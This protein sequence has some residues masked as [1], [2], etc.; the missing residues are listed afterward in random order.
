MPP[1]VR[2]AAAVVGEEGLDQDSGRAVQA[3][4]EFPEA[5]AP[6]LV[7]QGQAAVRALRAAYGMAVEGRALAVALE[8]EALGPGVEGAV[9][10]AGRVRG[11][12]RA[13]VMEAE[14][15]LAPAPGS[16]VP[17][18]PAAEDLVEAAPAQDTEAGV[19]PAQALEGAAGLEF[20]AERVSWAA[21]GLVLGAGVAL[22]A[23]AVPGAELALV[24]A[25]GAEQGPGVALDRG[26]A[27]VVA[28]RH[29]RRGSGSRRLLCSAAGPQ[30]WAASDLSVVEVAARRAAFTLRR[31]T[32]AR[33]W[34][35]SRSWGSPGKIPKES[36]M[37][38]HFSRD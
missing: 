19:R 16:E 18:D 20:L 2:A 15:G 30:R 29:N 17:V 12:D 38:P 3:R 34:A 21:P 33:C 24:G 1:K 10:V 5:V 9:S 26:A 23:E 27:W 11:P 6:A 14:L 8:L 13:Q 32:S 28:G 31:K 7:V 37:F 25:V 22:G 4:V 35:C 36:W